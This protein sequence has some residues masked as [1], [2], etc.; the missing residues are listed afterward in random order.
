MNI[1]QTHPVKELGYN[2]IEKKY[3]PIGEDEYHIRNIQNDG[4][5]YRALTTAELD[6]LIHNRNTSDNWNNILV[7]EKFN[8]TLIKN[9]KFYGLVRIG[10]LEA[11]HSTTMVP[12]STWAPST[13]SIFEP[14]GTLKR[15][16]TRASG[17]MR[18]HCS[19]RTKP[20]PA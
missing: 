4:K 8:A 15:S 5:D 13:T 10:M 12:F 19:C 20:T 16:I 11:S 6:T 17:P 14:T 7:T 2:F 9:C 3:I 18:S 1:I